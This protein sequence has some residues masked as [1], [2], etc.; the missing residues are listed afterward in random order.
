MCGCVV[1]TIHD[2]SGLVFRMIIKTGISVEDR[3]IR[4]EVDFGIVLI[5]EFTYSITAMTSQTHSEQNFNFSFAKVQ[6]RPFLVAEAVKLRSK[7]WSSSD[8]SRI[9]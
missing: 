2:A 9:R 1:R 5:R 3:L 6:V 4:F 7:Y 8:F